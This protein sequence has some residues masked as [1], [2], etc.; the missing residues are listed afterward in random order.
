MDLTLRWTDRC[1]KCDIELTESDRFKMHCPRCGVDLRDGPI[2]LVS[3]TEDQKLERK[4]WTAAVDLAKV[5]NNWGSAFKRLME[6]DQAPDYSLVHDFCTEV[7]ELSF[8]YLNRLMEESYTTQDSLSFLRKTLDDITSMLLAT[9]QELET[10][11]LL[12]GQWSEEDEE[13]KKEWLRKLGFTNK[14][15]A[16]SVAQQKRISCEG[17]RPLAKDC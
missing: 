7:M 12:T 3:L 14:L 1:W 15:L 11:Q 5:W 6:K 16:A 9:C 17:Q 13:I 8:P 2:D 10:I 4:C